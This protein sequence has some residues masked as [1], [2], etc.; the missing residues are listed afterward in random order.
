MENKGLLDS[1]ELNMLI[2]QLKEEQ[3]KPVDVEQ[4]TDPQALMQYIR[5]QN[6]NKK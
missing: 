3:Q 4:V 6:A 2:D 1:M 5:N